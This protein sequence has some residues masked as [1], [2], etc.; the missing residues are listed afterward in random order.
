MKKMNKFRKG[1]T[2]YVG[3]W[4]ALILVLWFAAWNYAAAYEL[5]QPKG[6]MNAY[7]E[8]TLHTR[9]EEAVAAYSSEKAN[10]YQSA[11]DV[12]SVLSSKLM[13]ADWSYRKS[14]EYST[15]TPVYT[16]YCGDTAMGTAQLQ[17]GKAGLLDFGLVP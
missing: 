14:K 10:D 7:M 1:F 4:A 9:L 11:E 6:A 13:E 17:Q 16:L 5:A 15:A 8:E 2:V 12:Q 3:I